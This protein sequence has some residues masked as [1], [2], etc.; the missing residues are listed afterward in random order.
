MQHVSM[1]VMQA[2]LMQLVSRTDILWQSAFSGLRDALHAAR[3]DDGHVGDPRASVPA[4]IMPW[5]TAV[6]PGP[7]LSPTP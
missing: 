6:F 3:L 1:T 4:A 5:L 2:T 7:S